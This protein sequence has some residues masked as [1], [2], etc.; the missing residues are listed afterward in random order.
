[1]RIASPAPFLYAQLTTP[2]RD[3]LP[4]AHAIS[5]RFP[6]AAQG[7]PISSWT[8]CKG[9]RV[10]RFDI[11]L[12]GFS[13]GAEPAEEGLQRL[14][15][16][17]KQRAIDLIKSLPRVVKREVPEEYALRYQHA[18]A[19]LGADFELRRCPIRPQQM[20]AVVGGGG[21]DEPLR[22][23]LEVTF[24]LPPPR[25]A[26][27]AA[28]R[29][30]S[31]VLGAAPVP[32]PVAIKPA[33]SA[34][35]VPRPNGPVPAVAPPA[36]VPATVMSP[37]VAPAATAPA[38]PMP[39]DPR[40]PDTVVDPPRVFPPASAA[41]TWSQ[42]RHPP[43]PAATAAAVPAP[44]P[45]PQVA[46][47]PA[48]AAAPAP[49]P[50]WQDFGD[51]LAESRSAVRVS[52]HPRPT[53]ATLPESK[54]PPVTAATPAQAPTHGYAAIP[55]AAPVPREASMVQLPRASLAP[56]SSAVNLRPPSL[57]I[58]LNNEP[59]PSAWQPAPAAEAHNGTPNAAAGAWDGGIDPKGR[60]GWFMDNTGM[61]SAPVTAPHDPAGSHQ[62]GG[63]TPQLRN[64][65]AP[66]RAAAPA[67][68]MRDERGSA[69]GAGH[70]GH[71]GR[72]AHGGHAPGHLA[73]APGHPGQGAVPAGQPGQAH[74]Q[75]PAGRRPPG[76]AGAAA[77]AVGMNAPNGPRPPEAGPAPAALGLIAGREL[78]TD[79]PSL[80]LRWAVRAVIGVSLFV[81][82][83]TVRHIR[84][85]DE[86]V[87]K[88]L[89][90]WGER[91]PPPEPVVPV[92]ADENDNAHPELGPPAVAWMES[93]YHQFSNGDKDRVRGLCDKFS[94]AGASE[95]HVGTITT[96]GMTQ[97]AGELIVQLP[98]DEVA[99]KTVL[100][101]YD[102]Y[103]QATFGGSAPPSTAP[104]GDQLHVTF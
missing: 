94:A 66:P 40:Y 6:T 90:S 59:P 50:Q 46:A 24:T 22:E 72:T 16:I 63:A 79:E 55:A 96:V 36:V 35:G 64:S 86:D 75:H 13:A 76:P 100:D 37:A 52:A 26:S 49:Q 11:Y 77:P 80:A 32:A 98:A 61:F 95:L 38:A 97:I 31:T 4:G 20:I 82:V 62:M 43:A 39:A 48:Y 71:P 87:E 5:P 15:G 47:A 69:P 30:N 70:P 14:F 84:A 53:H 33:D 51:T 83:T 78:A 73:H 2:P 57:A 45:V 29:I 42:S 88:V 44:A 41:A 10:E 101:V 68:G 21:S 65:L 85:F 103:L 89:A 8:R 28:Y 91:K 93:D 12:R 102:Q 104:E 19:V 54:P 25:P 17:D 58:P 92:K 99:R 27:S 34:D 1:V 74:G 23:E 7:D 81:I 9:V 3:A 56:P 60:P 67:V 18:L